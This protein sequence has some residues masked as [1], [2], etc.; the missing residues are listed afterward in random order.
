MWAYTYA[1]AQLV[2]AMACSWAVLSPRVNDGFWGKAALILMLFASLGCIAWAIRWPDEIQRPG[3][4][5]SV[6]VASMAV[7]CWWLKTW[8][9]GLRRHIKRRIRKCS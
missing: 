4:L 8:A 7:R 2:I 9:P 5:F 1:A 6:A 3:A